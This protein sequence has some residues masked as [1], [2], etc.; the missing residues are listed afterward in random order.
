[1]IGESVDSGDGPSDER[2][3]AAPPELLPLLHDLRAEP[4]AGLR[5]I[6]TEEP[7]VAAWLVDS[8]GDKTGVPR[9]PSETGVDAVL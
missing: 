7:D 1:M 5:V 8:A 3:L 2:L 4:V 9:W 6:G